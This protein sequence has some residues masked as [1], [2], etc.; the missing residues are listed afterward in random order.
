MG[1]LDL[2]A[3]NDEDVNFIQPTATY[4]MRRAF[5]LGKH[6]DY[7]LTTLKVGFMTLKA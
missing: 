1:N 6:Y 3:F 4:I 2:A 7:Y 5:H